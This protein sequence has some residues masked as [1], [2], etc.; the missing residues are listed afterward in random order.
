MFS[1]SLIDGERLIALGCRVGDQEEYEY[2][3]LRRLRWTTDVVE[4][5]KAASDDDAAARN[6]ER[7][8]SVPPSVGSWAEDL[9]FELERVQEGIK[10]LEMIDSP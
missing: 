3:R 5:L 4:A 6:F 10:V 8:T 9:G 2:W 1:D 7:A